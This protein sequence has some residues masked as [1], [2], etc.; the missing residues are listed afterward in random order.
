M[1]KLITLF[2]LFIIST[3][4][5]QMLAIDDVVVGRSDNPGLSS[6]YGDRVLQND[7][8]N[9]TPIVPATYANYTITTVVP[10]GVGNIVLNPVAGGFLQIPPNTPQGIYYITYEVYENANPSNRDTA[11]IEI[12]VFPATFNNGA[13]VIELSSDSPNGYAGG[14]NGYITTGPCVDLNTGTIPPITLSAD[15]TE[16]GA[17]DAY[18]ANAISF[19][20]PFTF[21]DTTGNTEIIN[22]DVWSSVINFLFPFKFYGQT[23]TNCVVSANGAISFNLGKAND[24]HAWS[25]N[26]TNQIP[27]NSPAFQGANIFGAMHDIDPRPSVN[28]QPYSI[29]YGV[30]GEAPFRVFMFAFDNPA[31]YNCN[32]MHT[33][34]MM[35]FYE[36]TNIVE[37][38]IFQKPVCSW[39]GGFAAIGIQNPGGTQGIA[40]PG[41]NTG[42]WD[43]NF[44]TPEAY[45]FIPNGA[46]VTTF[47]WLDEANNI[48]GTDPN[49]LVVTPTVTTTYIA[50]VTYTDPDTGDSTVAYKPITVVVPPSPVVSV[51]ASPDTCT[52]GDAVFTITGGE[53]DEVEY[54]INGGPTQTIIIDASGTYEITLTGI[55]TSQTINLLSANNLNSVCGGP[56]SV[57]ETVDVVPIPVVTITTNSP[58]CSGED[59]VFTLTGTPG[60]IVEYNTDGNTTESVTLDTFGEAEVTIIGATVDQTITLETIE[61]P[62]TGCNGALTDTETIV[63]TPIDDPSFTMAPTCD[64]GV[65]T[66]TGLPGGAF[67]FNPAPTDGAVIDPVTGTVTGGTPG[68]TYTI[69]YTTAGTCPDS[70]TEDVTVL[71]VADP[72]FETTA[73]CDGGTV[74]ILGD[75][76]GTFTLNP[77]PT[78]GATIDPGTG[79][80]TG[81]TPLATYTIEYTIG[82][83]CGASSMET[84]TVLPAEDASFTTTPDCTGGTMTITGDAGG[85]FAFNPVPTDSATIDAATGVIT[86]ATPGATYTIEYTTAGPCPAVSLENITILPAEDPSFTTTAT[87]DGGTATITGE[88][89]GTF[90]FNPV[91]SDGATI[92]PNT[93][94]VTG[95]TSGTTYTV[96]Y[97]TAGACPANSTETVT[98]ILVDD[99]SFTTTPDC[100][101]ATATITGDTGGTFAFNP[102]PTDGATIDPATGTI[103]GGTPGTTY[104]IE[105]TTAGTCIAS[106]I[107]TVTTHSLPVVVVPTPLFVCDDNIPDGETEMDLTVK[108][109]EISGGN[110]NYIV[111]YYNT[112]A[113]ADFG[114]PQVTPSATNYIG[115]NGEVVWVRVEDATTGCFDTTSLTLN[116]V[117]APAA[118]IPPDLHYC[119][120]NNDGYGVFDLDSNIPFIT[121]DPALEV[122][123]HQTYQNASD[124]VEPLSSPYNNVYLDQQEIYVR[125]DYVGATTDCPTIISF[126]IYVDKTPE[127]ELHPDP[128][129][130]CDDDGTAD[131]M[132]T[133]NLT[134]SN[135]EIL[136]GLSPLDYTVTYY[137]DQ[138][139]AEVGTTSPSYITTPGAFTNSNA[140]NQTVWVRVEN[141]TTTCFTVTSLDLIVNPLPVPVTT[142]EALSY[143]ICDDTI[144]NDGYAIFDLTVQDNVITGGNSTWT[145]N[146]F[147]TMADVTANNPIPDYT[148]YAN[149][150]IDGFP[151]N[152]QTIFVTVSSTENGVDCFALSTLTLIVNPVPTPNPVLPDLNLCDDTNSGDLEEAFDLTLNEGAMMI[153]YNETPTYHTTMA[154]AESGANAIPDPT[155]YVSQTRTIYVRVTNTGDPNIPADNGTGCYTIVSFEIVVNPLPVTTPVDDILACELNTDGFYTFDLTVQNDA[156][157]NGQ[158]EPDFEVNYYTTLADAQAGTGAIANPS[159]YTNMMDPANPGQAVN[160]QEIFVNIT[161]TLT[162]CDVATVSFLIEVQEAAEVNPNYDTYALCDDNMEFDG[163]PSNDTV[164]FDLLSQ[165]TILLNGQDP[166]NF[167]ITYYESED[168]AENMNEA[169][170]TSSP[171][172]NTSNPQIIWVRIDNNTNANS[173]C[174]DVKPLTLQVDPIPA[175]DLKDVY[176]ICVNLNGTEVIGAPLMDT[177]LSST[178]YTFEWIEDGAPTVVLST[179][180]SYMPTVEGTYTVIVT[181]NNNLCVSSDTAVVQLSSPPNLTATLV[182]QAFAN[183]NVIEVTATGDGAALFEF[184]LDNGPWLS[185]EPNGNTYTFNNVPFGEHTIQARDINGCGLAVDTVLVMDYPLFFTPNNDGY[186]DTWQIFGIQN[187]YDAQIFIYDRYGKLLKQLNPGGPGWDGTYNGELLPSSDYW[188]TIK[189]RELGESQG[190]Q[191]EFK[192]HFSLKR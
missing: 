122:S 9:G 150:A 51:T 187:Q 10:D 119:D 110:T 24:Y 29:S 44:M 166:A 121:T 22:D 180:S 152:P 161:N 125:V 155:A 66:V 112:Q 50:Q 15:Y 33:S 97:T 5:A 171:Y 31:Q 120:P 26:G 37:T 91:P 18:S 172:V 1:K 95:G 11:E 160:P 76:G 59:A 124:N 12:R 90:T 176:T 105:Y 16:I 163:N 148:A 178:S 164:A 191:K 49:A 147:E 132:T 174:Y 145:V 154:D 144:D 99:P 93:G 128:I 74:N 111:T 65:A 135:T 88:I 53:N 123:F 130:L 118:N 165:N 106:S 109:D 140:P 168:D 14:T 139:G 189:Y 151:H 98:V 104:S 28:S 61:N 69:E 54:N 82:G 83:T 157:L 89:G 116:V 170:D 146:Y 184:S 134:S 96:E 169:I 153:A 4:Y 133:F 101:G 177:G 45:Q 108:N 40:A 75:T 62:S 149:T 102:A 67:A 85:V 20:P 52:G 38:Y 126:F 34:Q 141:N 156:I 137:T 142:T 192:A 27:N 60:D 64:G 81:G 179:D 35:L 3:S 107:E 13:S 183:S 39:N 113:A 79:T 72:S 86:N 84:V 32:D 87:C 57:S 56:M 8:L 80:I 158:P 71:T 17:T 48:I 2:C 136:N 58:I 43:I 19:N 23:Y 186:N 25:F 92:D 100:Y 181:D 138:A 41:R 6:A 103:T 63:V 188:F 70:S 173:I 36:T 94:T 47:Q 131:G 68:A 77:M 129:V 185:N 143:E 182:T 30:K 78:D 190:P 55:T 159:A 175:F 46:V 42:V 115:N 21:G 114:S 7:Y 162:T 117:E 73:T 127:I 167:I